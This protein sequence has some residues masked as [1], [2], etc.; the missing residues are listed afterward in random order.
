MV[1]TAGCAT[2]VVVTAVAVV[3]SGPDDAARAHAGGSGDPATLV[4][5]GHERF[6]AGRRADALAA[7][8]HAM[9]LSTKIAASDDVRDNI[10]KT[11]DGKDAVASVIALE[12]LASSVKPPVREPII[13]AASSGKVLEVR[14]RAFAIAERDGFDAKVDRVESWSLDLQ[15]AASCEDRKIAIDRLASANDKRAV[16]AIKRARAFKCVE[17]AADEA[18]ARLESGT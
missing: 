3:V 14:H 2:L 4:A 7:Y 12:L 17:K 5:L 11:L 15:Q 18:I 9:R 10:T 16:A 6:A 1:L 13:A 8:E